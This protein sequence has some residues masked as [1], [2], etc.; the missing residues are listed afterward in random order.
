[1]SLDKKD[2]EEGDQV[3]FNERKVPLEVVEVEQSRLHLEG[4]HGGEYVVFEAEETEDLLVANKKSG[5][6]YA[7]Y[8]RDL[9]EIGEWI[10]GG[11]TWEHSKTGNELRLIRKDS[12][13]WTLKSEDFDLKEEIELPKYGYS[14]KEFAVEDAKDFI[15]KHPEGEVK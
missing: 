13:F 14:E 12:G 10:R 3:L 1:M 15:E 6:R 4:P 8:C 11:D 2:I 7:T 5:R 9:R